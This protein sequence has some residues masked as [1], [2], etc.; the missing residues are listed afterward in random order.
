VRSHTSFQTSARNKR[1][2]ENLP[3]FSVSFVFSPPG[4]LRD[5]TFVDLAL[6]AKV[7]IPKL[8]DRNQA[9]LLKLLT[10]NAG[11]PPKSNAFATAAFR[12]GKTLAFISPEVFVPELLVK[13]KSDLDPLNLDFIGAQ[14][15]GIWATPAGTAFV[16]GS[17]PFD[18]L[19]L[20]RPAT[21]RDR[22][23]HLL[24]LFLPPFTPVIALK[25]AAPAAAANRST[26]AM[27]KWD[28]EVRESAAK[29]RAAAGG[30][31][32]VL[33]KQDQALVTAQLALE[34]DVRA[35]I[36]KVKAQMERGLSLI[37]SLIEAEVTLFKDQL[38]ETLQLILDGPLEKGSFLVGEEAFKTFLVSPF[39]SETLW[40][41]GREKERWKLIL[42]RL[43]ANDSFSETAAPLDS[44][45]FV[46]SL[47][48][49]SSGTTESRLYPRT[50]RRSLSP[51]NPLRFQL[52][53]ESKPS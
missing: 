14:E 13:I 19:S 30:G 45:F 53:F 31:A 23:S 42:T 39:I 10:D 4:T 16:D 41:D 6:S 18:F 33:S 37:K 20:L 32:V 8:V 49:P 9:K 46:P 43:F 24:S 36:V 1:R 28:Q 25:K 7:N 26:A 12:A 51:V 52:L 44:V 38:T 29:K 5:R 34:A 48:S 15:L 17:F 22:N 47:E 2:H 40:R 21:R 11:A 3:V 50:C 35:R 27:D